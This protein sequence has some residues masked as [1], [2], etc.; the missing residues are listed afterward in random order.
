MVARLGGAWQG[1]TGAVDA[2]QLSELQR[3]IATVI[4]EMEAEWAA[5]KG[6]KYQA[7]KIKTK[8]EDQYTVRAYGDICAQREC[9]RQRA[10]QAVNL[11]AWVQWYV[12]QHTCPG[13]WGRFQKFFGGGKADK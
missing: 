2:R 6:N 11:D 5:V 4:A 9:D 12:G 10:G 1:Q 8:T 3:D 13:R 7:A